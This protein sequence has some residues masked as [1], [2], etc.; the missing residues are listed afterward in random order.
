M[1]TSGGRFATAFVNVP[2]QLRAGSGSACAKKKKTTAL[3]WA[4][5]PGSASLRNRPRQRT[6]RS[7]THGGACR[8]ASPVLVRQKVS[9][10]ASDVA[11]AFCGAAAAR[12]GADAGAAAGAAAAGFTAGIDGATLRRALTGAA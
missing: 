12:A 8:L 3:A 1:T 4:V 10:S 5:V 11:A 2:E 9:Q 6:K 7:L